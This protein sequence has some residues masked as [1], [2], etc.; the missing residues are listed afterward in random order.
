MSWRS[1]SNVI[2]R[3]PPSKSGFLSRPPSSAKNYH[4]DGINA[5]NKKMITRIVVAR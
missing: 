1:L 3:N 5:G 4:M 2:G